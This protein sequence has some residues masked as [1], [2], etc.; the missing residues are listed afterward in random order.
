MTAITINKPPLREL[1]IHVRFT[2][3]FYLRLK[4]GLLMLRLAAIILNCNVDA[5]EI[6]S[7]K[8]SR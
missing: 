6:N 3:M 1:T 5:E 4:L 7:Q 2:K 8:E